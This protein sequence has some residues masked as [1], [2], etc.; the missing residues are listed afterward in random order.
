MYV[1]VELYISS[2]I[3]ALGNICISQKPFEVITTCF[4]SYFADGETE[5]TRLEHKRVGLRAY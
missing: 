2:S 5:V 3:S 1:S 4:S